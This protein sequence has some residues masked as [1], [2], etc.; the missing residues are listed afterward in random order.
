MIYNLKCREYK[1]FGSWKYSVIMLYQTKDWN[2]LP[3]HLRNKACCLYM[4]IFLDQKVTCIYAHAVY[5]HT[6][7]K[8]IATCQRNTLTLL[9]PLSR[10]PTLPKGS[11]FIARAPYTIWWSSR[12]RFD[13]TRLINSDMM[14]RLGKFFFFSNDGQ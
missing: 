11:R 4:F 14:G 3:L 1:N 9:A 2:K 10:H 12:S 6:Y 5:P 8:H 13:H 7:H